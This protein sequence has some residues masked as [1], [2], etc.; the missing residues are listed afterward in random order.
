[1]DSM[2]AES[3]MTG[4]NQVEQWFDLYVDSVQQYV[5][6]R[7][8]F[9]LAQDVVADTFRVAIEEFESFDPRRGDARAWQVTIDPGSFPN[10]SDAPVVRDE[11]GVARTPGGVFEADE[12]VS[13]QVNTSI[14]TMQSPI[15]FN[16]TIA[17]YGAQQ[18]PTSSVSHG[19]IRVPM[20]TIDVIRSVVEVGDPV[21]V[22]NGETEPEEVSEEDQL[23]SFNY[24]DPNS[25]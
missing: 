22:W 13:G 24:P 17:I 15:F 21:L 12:M 23:P 14:G 1:M 25:N 8:G 5:A 4:G 9:D 19:G 2:R 16:D 11:C 3:A 10:T 7:V 18:V 6:R 20:D